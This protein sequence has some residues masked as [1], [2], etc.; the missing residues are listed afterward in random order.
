MKPG[1]VETQQTLIEM[2]LFSKNNF[3]IYISPYTAFSHDNFLIAHNLGHYLM[4]YEK[5]KD[6]Y[7]GSIG[8]D[9]NQANR[10]AA[11]LL[12]PKKKF[13][14]KCKKYE[15]TRILA[16]IFGVKEETIVERKRILECS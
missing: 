1:K 9:E 13:I 10:F 5:S 15:D 3:I 2:K 12:M 8:P 14:K 6:F 7:I 11:S 16:A 4:H